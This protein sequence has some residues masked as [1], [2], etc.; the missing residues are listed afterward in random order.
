[1]CSDNSPLA[2][3]VN[4]VEDVGGSIGDIGASIDD[5]VNENI[6]GGWYTVGAVALG[7]A[8]LAG[9]LAG[10]AGLTA[11]EAA[12]LAESAALADTAM[13]GA[14]GVG[15]GAAGAGTVGAGLTA[16]EMAELTALAP[17]T[18]TSIGSG[19]SVGGAIGGEQLGSFQMGQGTS[20]SAEAANNPLSQFYST[21]NPE[22]SANL[23][24]VSNLV[25]GGAE[26]NLAALNS[27]SSNPLLPLGGA[28]IGGT[29]L[30]SVGSII[31]S[32]QGLGQQ[33]LGQVL[34][35]TGLNGISVQ[36]LQSPNSVYSTSPSLTDIARAANTAKNVIKALTPQEQALK[37][38][39]TAQQQSNMANMLRGT[40]LAQ[41]ALP[42]IYKQANPFNFGQQNQPVQDTNVLANLLRK[43]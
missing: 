4:F 13:A 39:Q 22:V 34:A 3:P 26:S 7:G 8:G 14:G 9:G 42:P 21:A 23:N 16:A 24:T 15:A 41:T 35:P 6:P 19:T 10:T 12:A 36:N 28:G 18:G 38:A 43:A 11:A 30:G 17:E 37:N 32:G 33:T 25:G 31:G 1:M 5:A 2:G 27:L 29:E 20:L 40:Q